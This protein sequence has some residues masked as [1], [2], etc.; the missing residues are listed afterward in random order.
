MP[1]VR[2]RG[3]TDGMLS[4]K[5]ISD[6]P[7]LSCLHYSILKKRDDAGTENADLIIGVIRIIAADATPNAYPNAYQDEIDAASVHP[8]DVLGTTSK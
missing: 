1:L 7:H 8:E 6:W 3:K 2:F 5:C 4:A